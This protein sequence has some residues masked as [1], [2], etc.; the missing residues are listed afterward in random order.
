MRV[1]PRLLLVEPLGHPDLTTDR[2]H[3]PQVVEMLDDETSHHAAADSFQ[4]WFEP[5]FGPWC[6]PYPKSRM[7]VNPNCGMG[8]IMLA[9]YKATSVLWM[10]MLLILGLR[11]LWHLPIWAH[12]LETLGWITLFL[13]PHFAVCGSAILGFSWDNATNPGSAWAGVKYALFHMFATSL[14]TAAP[15]QRE[16]ARRRNDA[17]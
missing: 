9:S 16:R 10:L 6:S 13:S 4:P 8:A 17:W 12:L 2:S 1:D 15:S 3:D 11:F 14:L 7:W 5:T